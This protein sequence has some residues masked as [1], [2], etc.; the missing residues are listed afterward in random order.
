VLFSTSADSRAFEKLSPT[1]LV[2][3]LNEIPLAM[4]DIVFRQ[5]RHARSTSATR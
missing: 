4:T 3:L 1:A 2:H 5:A